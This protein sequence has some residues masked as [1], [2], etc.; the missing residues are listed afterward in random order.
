MSATPRNH[1]CM[2]V[3]TVL[4]ATATWATAGNDDDDGHNFGYRHSTVCEK[5]ANKMFRSCR[6]EINEE[7]FATIAK[8][9]NQVD[10]DEPSQK[11]CQKIA[12]E[13]YQ[14]ERKGCRDQREA[15]EDICELLGE[16]RYGPEDLLDT[17]NFVAE[18]DDSNPY[19]SLRPGHTYVAVAGENFEETIVVTVTDQVREVLGVNCRKVVDV[20]LIE[21]GGD[22]VPVEVT[23]DYYAQALNGD[24]H[25][26][27]EVAR[28]FEDGVLNN[29]DGSFEAGRGL[30]KSGILI[31]AQ[32][33]SGDAHRQEY[34]LGEAEDVIQYVA[35][36]DNPT[37]VGQGEGGENP[38]FPCAGAC[39]KT[40]EFIPPEP[41]VGEFKYFLPGTGFVLG[42]ALEDGIPT[43]ERDE[44]ICTGDSLAVLSDAKC[45]LN[46]PDELLD[47]LCELSP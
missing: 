37:S 27:G 38:D 34:L 43:G 28:N 22:L 29:L 33:A 36:V 11:K 17:G 9:L 31:K 5:S 8:C 20:V 18:P 12:R 13:T 30:A 16:D 10:S 7:Y 44:V 46:N 47:K 23:D 14:E 35:G 45:G 32:P 6:F 21:E 2:A 40:E 3:A 42:V 39:V 26:C 24:V 15:R 25:Y 4:L 41:G 19:F 1:L